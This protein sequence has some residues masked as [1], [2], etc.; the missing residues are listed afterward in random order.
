LAFWTKNA[1]W[2]VS[3]DG[4]SY[5]LLANGTDSSNF[6]QVAI[7]DNVVY[8]VDWNEKYVFVHVCASPAVLQRSVMLSVHLS[9]TC[10]VPTQIKKTT[11]VCFTPA[12]VLM[13]RWAVFYVL[14][15]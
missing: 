14:G 3:P 9:H 13:R 2:K 5:S 15:T 12:R 6:T 10:R 4:A 7:L 8:F 1:V 11:A